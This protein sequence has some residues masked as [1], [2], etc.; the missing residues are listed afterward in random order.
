MPVSV[1]RLRAPLIVKPC[2]VANPADQQHLVVLVVAAVAAPF[3]RLE[4]GEFLL[5]IAQHIRLHAAQIAD[6]TD[7][8]VALGWYGWERFLHENQQVQ[9]R[10]LRLYSNSS[11]GGMSPCTTPLSL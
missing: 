8:E 6:L 4:L 2:S 10:K 1:S 7:G 3:H 11:S 9:G 5:P